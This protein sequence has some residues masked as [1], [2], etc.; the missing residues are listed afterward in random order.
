MADWETRISS[1]N[2]GA[3][4][5]QPGRAAP[6]PARAD[7]AEVFKAALDRVNASQQEATALANAYA[8]NDPNVSLEETMIAAS[9]ANI[10]FQALVQVR[11]KLVSAYHDIMNMQI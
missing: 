2:P 5:Q 3:Y 9:K 11:N 10:S 6:G 1:I 4:L 8:M 7:F